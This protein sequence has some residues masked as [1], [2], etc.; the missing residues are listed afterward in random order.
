MSICKFKNFP[1]LYPRTPVNKG[2]EKGGEKKRGGRRR[3]GKEKGRRLRLEDEEEGRGWHKEKEE[4]EKEG[5]E[6][7]TLP[8]F[9]NTPSLNYLEISLVMSLPAF[10]VE[11]LL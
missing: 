5:K 7:S 2:R 11:S 4:R 6:G 1:G 3:D 9:S 10:Y 8:V